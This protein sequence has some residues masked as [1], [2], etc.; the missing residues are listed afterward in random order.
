MAQRATVPTGSATC[1]QSRL[2]TNLRFGEPGEMSHFTKAR[3]LKGSSGPVAEEPIQEG[4]SIGEATARQHRV[5]RGKSVF[6]VPEQP[7]RLQT[8][9]GSDVLRA[10]SAQCP[11]VRHIHPQGSSA[12]PSPTQEPQLCFVSPPA[13][14]QLCPLEAG[15]VCTHPTHSTQ[16]AA[17]LLEV[18]QRHAV[19]SSSHLTSR[20]GCPLQAST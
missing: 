20:G 17:A 1:V 11:A 18:S 19:F 6:T 4:R 16:I 15:A 10:C 3:F 7:E 12:T 9:T 5:T 14:L 8:H 13:L 2:C